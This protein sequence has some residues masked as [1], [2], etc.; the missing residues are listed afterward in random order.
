MTL[1]LLTALLSANDN[2]AEFRGPSG[3]GHSDSKGLPRE[4]SESS[5]VLW[6]TAIRGKG[7]SS[8]VVWGKQVWL[9]SAAA[10][11]KEHY[12]V[13]VDR[14]SGKILLDEKVVD[15]KVFE[16]T[17][18]PEAV[19][20]YYE[21]F[22]KF[23]SFASPSPVIEEGRVYLHWGANGTACLDTATLKPVWVRQD[24]KC[25]HHRGAGSSP[26][27]WK[28]LLILTFDGFDQQFVLALDKAT[29][30]QVWRADR[31][32]DFRT[33][34]GDQKK[35]YGTPVVFEIGGRSLLVSPAARGLVA[36]DPETGKQVWQL[37]H[38]QHSAASRPLYG[39]GMIFLSTGFGKSELLAIR[40]EGSG[41]LGA[42][43][44]AWKIPKGIGSKPSPLLVG[45]FLFVGADG[46]LA[47]CFEAKTGA[48][49]WQQR[50]GKASF[51]ASP[52]YADGVV[53][54][55][56]EDGSTVAVDAAAREFKE[57]GKGKLD[58]GGVMGTPA[59]AGKSLFIRTEGNLYRVEAK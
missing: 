43:A 9:T 23:N 34:D 52:I 59:I 29:G 55:F 45:E 8:P 53:Y 44:I 37:L 20:K 39:N 31:A 27:L 54:F 32:H 47:S 41:D 26:I 10:D 6:K 22:K 35:G 51:T 48:Q 38:D 49:V 42:G 5:N 19:K 25:D 57:L 50:V 1:L 17:H 15:Q 12:A 28:N 36:L 24:I 40:P 14:D 16:T 56:G 30:K 46:G 13:C 7:W 11:G 18:D 3:T 33:G 58:Q 4:W 21:L 2:W